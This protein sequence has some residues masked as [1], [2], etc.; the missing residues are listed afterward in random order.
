[1]LFVEMEQS[2]FFEISVIRISC[3]WY[4]TLLQ[5]ELAWF[6]LNFLINIMAKKTLIT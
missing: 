1:M 4:V 6:G 3:Y 5:T 2:A